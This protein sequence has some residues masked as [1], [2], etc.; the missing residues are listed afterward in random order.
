MFQN[1]FTKKQVRDHLDKIKKIQDT[2]PETDAVIIG[3]T[4]ADISISTVITLG[5]SK[6]YPTEK[7]MQEV[8]RKKEYFLH[9]CAFKVFL[10]SFRI[11][12]QIDNL[13]FLC[14]RTNRCNTAFKSKYSH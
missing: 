13:R 3:H 1:F 2:L 7:Q 9:F 8:F 4:G 6:E 5:L 12:L 11:F 10:F 14:E